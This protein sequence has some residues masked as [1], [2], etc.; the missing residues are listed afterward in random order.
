MRYRILVSIFIFTLLTVGVF[1]QSSLQYPWYI[2]VH[3]GFSQLYG[4]IQNENNPLAKFQDETDFG[5]GFRAGRQIVPYLYGHLQ[6]SNLGLKG[7]KTPSSLQF[8]S[9]MNEIQ[10][11]AT[12]NLTHLVFG[13]KERLFNVYFLTGAGFL[14]MNG[15]TWRTETASVNDENKGRQNA[16]KT[17]GEM[18]FALPVA[19]GLDVKLS[20]RIFLNLEP[21]LRLTNTDFPDGYERGGHNDAYFYTSLGITYTFTIDKQKREIVVPPEIAEKE[22]SHYNAFINIDYDFPEDLKSMDQF[23]L[24]CTIHKGNIQGPA[25]LTQVLPI[26]FNV[27][28]TAID[29]ARMEFQNYT[30]SLYWDELPKDS[31]FTIDY[32]VRLDKIYGQ[33]PMTSILYLDEM[34]KEFRF[35]TDVF[36]RRKIVAEPIVVKEDKLEDEK[37]VS[38]SEKVEFRIQ[39]RASYKKP[40]S[41]DSLSRYLGLNKPIIEE[42]IGNWYKYSIGSFKTYQEAR[43]YR[44]ELIQQRKLNDAFIIAYYE[45]QRLN[46]LSELQDLAPDVLPGS[47]QPEDTKYVESGTCY[48]IQILALQ[49]SKVSPSVLQGMYDLGEE[50][51]NEEVYHNWRKYTVGKCLTKTEALD[52]RKQLIQKGATGAFV[53]KFTDGQRA[54]L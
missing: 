33:L 26:G 7:V 43:S 2:T 23:K 54:G 30:L 28:D 53:V 29:N 18:G 32:N 22:K 12:V 13:E 50:D 16:I 42:K 8:E 15:E 5:F 39:L 31:V 36:I 46:T 9:R 48:R 45:G 11:G 35:K 51:V 1:A 6:Y 21:G 27:M 10:L 24:S 38:P 40:I 19:F 14:I 37:M 52:L 44:N 4:D 47:K 3:G 20:N 41:V 49:K 25:E 17:S 34:K